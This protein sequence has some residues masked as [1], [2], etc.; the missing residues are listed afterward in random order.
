MAETIDVEKLNE[1]YNAYLEEHL[2]P[3]LQEGIL[4]SC[5]V[6]GDLWKYISDLV[7]AGVDRY[8]YRVYK[9]KMYQRRSR[10]GGLGDPRNVQIE[11][12]DI[13]LNGF[14]IEF[15]NIAGPGP[16]NYGGG[17]DGMIEDDVLYGTNYK[18]AN[19]DTHKQFSVPRNFYAVYEEEY[20]PDEAGEILISKISEQAKRIMY[21]AA[22]KALQTIIEE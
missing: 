9:P 13:S 8:V 22:L 3:V 4:Q 5:A 1:L 20:S 2:L 15:H 14:D 21:T 18:F 7:V 11:V 6:G 10:Y 12:G 19:R 16:T 17:G